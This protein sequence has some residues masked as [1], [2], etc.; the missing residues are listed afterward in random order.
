MEDIEDFGDY[1]LLPQSHCSHN[2]AVP[3][4]RMAL[5]LQSQIA[6]PLPPPTTVTLSDAAVLHPS[7]PCTPCLISTGAVYVPTV[8]TL[9]C[10][11]VCIHARLV[12]RD[13]DAATFD[14]G[15]QQGR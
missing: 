1:K 11:G 7:T 4:L 15:R 10:A 8:S 9:T 14:G 12:K 3:L 5:L 13:G 2:D 6:V